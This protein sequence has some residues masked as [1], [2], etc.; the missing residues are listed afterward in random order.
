MTYAVDNRPAKG[1]AI[2]ARKTVEELLK[3]RDRYDLTFIHY[4]GCD[5]PIYGHG[6]PEVLFPT[7]KPNLLNKRLLRQIYY[8]L[9]TKDS[10]DLIQWFQ[11]RL[12]PLFWLAPAKRLVVA[13]HGAG[14]WDKNAPFDLMRHVFN[15]T[16]RLFR[17]SIDT[18]LVGSSY[19]KRDVMENYKF[20]D[21]QVEVILNGADES[22]YP[23]SA[24]EV[25]AVRE[26][27]KLPAKFLM[28]VARLNHNKNAFRT[29][30]AFDR[31]LKD[32]RDD[33]T[34]FVNIG[35][36]GSEQQEVLGF[37]ARSDFRN[38]ISLV[39]YVDAEDLPAFYCASSGLVFPLLFEGFGLPAI[40]A[41]RCGVPVV[42][43]KTAYPEISEEEALLVDPESEEEIANAMR[44]LISD[45]AARARLAERGYKKAQDFTW[46]AMGEQLARTYDRILG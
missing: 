43:S 25:E 8:F 15:W 3:M 12:Y 23:R 33:K 35:A 38:R 19:A 46:K 6:V 36:N 44:I 21:G 40:E 4:D 7:L 14:D 31:Y 11:P 16:V 39:Q 9:T 22:F 10:Y 13:V 24:A 42:V 45:G 1:T 18:A 17:R 20:A 41:M 29:I 2:V 30:R 34:C 5:D 26:K 27:Y 28:N 32:S 37:L